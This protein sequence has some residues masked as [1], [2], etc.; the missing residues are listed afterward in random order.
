MRLD[1]FRAVAA[2]IALTS[3]G[4]QLG[5]FGP[6]SGQTEVQYWRQLAER[7]VRQNAAMVEDM[8]ALKQKAD[9]ANALA[10]ESQDTAIHAEK[11]MYSMWVGWGECQS[12]MLKDSKRRSKPLLTTEGQWP[13]PEDSKDKVTVGR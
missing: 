8:K 2:A 1:P 9:D 11:T 7:A 10:A 5:H 3:L 12:L 6:G 13:W 4:W